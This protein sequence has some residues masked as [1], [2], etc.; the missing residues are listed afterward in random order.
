MS[1]GRAF[2][3]G[4]EEEVLLVGPRAQGHPLAPV[5]GEILERMVLPSE[6]AAGHEIYAAQ[7]ELRSPISATSAE[8]VA[9]LAQRRQ[10]A[11][12]AGATL[13]AAGLHPTA[14]FGLAE[15]VDTPRYRRVAQAMSGLIRRAP[16]GALHVHIGMPDAETAIRAYNG[17]RIHLPLL[18]ALAANSPFWF[19][20][21]SGL[22]TA[23]W[24]MVRSYPGRGI[25]PLLRDVAHYEEIVARAA[26]AGG[27]DDYT[28][29]LWD[30]RPHPRLGTV[31]VREMDAQG[32]LGDAHALAGLVR[33]LAHRAAE[34]GAPA[35]PPPREALGW[36]AFRAARDGL[37]AEVLD[38]AGEVRRV[39][40]VARA[41]ARQLAGPA[42][43]LGEEE[44]LAALERLLAGG[45]APART[46][47]A[48]RAGADP[49]AVL[50]D[51]TD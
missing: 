44:A 41:L 2:T 20:R 17:L 6:A 33:L 38:G 1:W 16:E 13:L 45:G 36:S 40:D 22:A 4:V 47:A 3:V 11:R 32:R 46:R 28:H 49:A 29:L 48:V 31:E 9:A 5:A 21:D 12:A 18:A 26:T 15:L 50:V 37:A 30:V 42:R 39:P 51:A 8:A 27:F 7:V 23:R 43:E 25:P 19:G 35:P 34:G 24:G 14:P 10:A